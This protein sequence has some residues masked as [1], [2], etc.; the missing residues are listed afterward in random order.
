MIRPIFYVS[1]RTGITAETLGHGLLTQFDAVEFNRESLRFVD[2][3]DKA[4]EAAARIDDA[5]RRSGVHPIV[6]STLID[7]AVRDIVADSTCLFLDLFDAFID[8]LEREL[9]VPSSH[10][11]GRTH[12]LGDDHVAG[13]YGR[14]IE[15][16]NYALAHDDG[17]TTRN[18]E[19][20]DVVLLGVSR[21]GKTPTCLYLGLRYGLYAANYPLTEEDLEGARLPRAL[22]PHKQT[23]F[24][25]TIRPERLQQ[26][27]A[28]RRPDSRYASLTQCRKEVERAES[29]YHG[30]SIPFLD[31]SQ[32]SIEEIAAKIMVALAGR[33]PS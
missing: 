26:I 33:R 11:I 19:Q 10:A 23:L 13:A 32:T 3:P 1:D 16:V 6:F 4:R 14:R 31:T 21:S 17:V 25:L 22:E 15:A 5:A 29:L 2:T 8:P 18:F 20:A 24:G 28:E 7:P 12:G 30:Y 27:R 9:G